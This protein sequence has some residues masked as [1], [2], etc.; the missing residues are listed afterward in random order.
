M[1]ADVR[2]D[3]A[4]WWLAVGAA[5]LAGLAL[6]VLAAQ[7][8]LWTDE[9]WSMIY[10]H[11]A[12]DPL[13]VFLRINH[14]NNHHLYSL[15]LQAIG[16]AAPPWLVR[17]PAIVAGTVA[18]PLAALVVARRSPPAGLVAAVLFAVSPV[19][20]TFG[21]EARG[22]SLMLAAALTMLL[23]V[24]A[25]L[26]SGWKAWM[27]W[28][29]ALC[30]ALGM[31]SHL[32]MAAPVALIALW[33]YLDRRAC[34]GP[35]EGMRTA[36]RLMGPAVGA[37]VAVIA[38][39]LAAAAASPTGMRIGGY[40]PFGWDGYGVALDDLAGWTLGVSGIA[41]WMGPALLAAVAAAIAF[42]PP[43]W[44]GS[45]GRLYAIL[46][47]G[48]PL[49]VGLL[50][51][52]NAAFARY[53]LSSALGLL[54]LASEWI[55][56]GL[57]AKGTPRAVSATALATILLVSLWHDSDLVQAKRGRPDETVQIMARTAPRGARVAID[58]H[59][60]EGM[61][62]LAAARAGY[63]LDIV[64]GCAPARFVIAGQGRF[65]PA[66][67]RLVHCGVQMRALGSEKGT[68][69][70]GDSWILYG[71]EGLQRAGPPVSGPALGALNSRRF[72]RAGV[73]QG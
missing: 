23:L 63:A 11:E 28:C 58:R 21:S 42:R 36:A 44:L 12:R 9:A 10:A 40:L 22:Y 16:M 53:Y 60:F 33:A 8:G 54:L 26:R 15:W 62:T 43:A 1:I 7:G 48:V 64:D 46:M 14:D 35:S 20:V 72:G 38:F 57:G 51:P 27:P 6:R 49:G 37:T 67:D 59:G 24:T 30:A 25:A 73:A 68:P 70:S 50:H 47:L 34:L 18:I 71:A 31:L 65:G 3:R 52:G 55:G 29:L 2:A 41:P 61:L 66:P 45:Q 69:L 17:L 13:G 5:A 56:R 4:R 19:L 39:V 32:S